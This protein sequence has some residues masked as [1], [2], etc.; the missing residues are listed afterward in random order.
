MSSEGSS[1]SDSGG[2]GAGAGEADGGGTV[3][4]RLTSE[5]V[6]SPPPTAIGF[7]A[8]G[9]GRLSVSVGSLAGVAA[10]VSSTVE[11]FP[12]VHGGISRNS[13]KVRTRVLQHF[14][15]G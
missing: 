8:G 6:L 2:G 11:C 1:D 10:G 13:S 12:V 3:A 14:Q 9:S 7:G 5:G 15:P 4:G